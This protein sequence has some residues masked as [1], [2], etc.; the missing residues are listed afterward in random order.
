MAKRNRRRKTFHVKPA[1]VGLALMVLL[2]LAPWMGYSLL[3]LSNDQLATQIKMLEQ[4]KR[5]E[6]ES[7]RRITLEKDRLTETGALQ[8]AVK[9]SG[10]NLGFA[11]PDRSVFVAKNGRLKLDGPVEKR[12]I[13]AKN[14][15]LGLT[16]DTAVA[17]V[18]TPRRTP[19]RRTTRTR[20]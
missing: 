20:R 12:L 3:N 7:L 18:E 14:R 6:E 17:Q 15:K 10:L 16:E 9:Q 4:D 13:A 8:A 11:A 5:N 1:T 2:I 19:S